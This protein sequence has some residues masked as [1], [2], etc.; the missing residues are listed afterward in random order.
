[1]TDLS[2][3]RS[4]R[5]PVRLSRMTAW[6]TGLTCRFKPKEKKD[7]F[8]FNKRKNLKPEEVA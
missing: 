6:M 4:L 8:S 1:L 3:S 7:A 5:S 2:P